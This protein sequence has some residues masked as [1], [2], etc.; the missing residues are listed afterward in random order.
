MRNTLLVTSVLGAALVAMLPAGAVGAQGPGDGPLKVQATTGTD[1]LPVTGVGVGITTCAAG[2]VL[3]TLTTG[4][5]GTVT[6]AFPS[7]C[8][9]AQVTSVPSGCEL[10]SIAYVQVNVAPGTT[11]VACFQFRCA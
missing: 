4:R 1:Q 6:Q 3:T 7:G 8:Y 10:A 2:P 11:Q 5:D 9:Q